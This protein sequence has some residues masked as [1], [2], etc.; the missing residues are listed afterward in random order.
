MHL[1]IGPVGVWTH[2]SLWSSSADDLAEAAAAVDQLGY[3]AIW[4]G[5][6]AGDLALPAAVL[7]ATQRLIVATAI[8][9]IWTIPPDRLAAA[10]RRVARTHADRLLVGLGSSHAA[11]VEQQTGQRYERPLARLGRYLDRL[12]AVEPPVPI[13]RRVLAALGPR[14][15]ELAARRSAGPLPYLV[16][17]EYTRRAR[18]IVGPQALLAVE[19]KVVLETDPER[20]RAIARQT[21][22]FYLNLPNYIANLRRLGFAEADFEAGGSDRLVDALVAWGDVEAVTARVADHL[23]AGAD[24]VGIQVLTVGEGRLPRQQWRALA[25]TLT[26]LRS[27]GAALSPSA[28]AN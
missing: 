14:A 1:A 28:L 3:G 25:P 4:L 24:H 26:S 27:T 22:G 8:V 5:D 10:Y 20:A 12:D 19:Q 2:S 23:A 7:A 6:A 15:L 9:N 18:A 21:F 17:P 16:T 13:E 11:F